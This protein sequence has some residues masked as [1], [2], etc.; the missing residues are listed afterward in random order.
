MHSVIKLCIWAENRPGW[1]KVERGNCMYWKKWV[2]LVTL[3]WQEQ[4]K[5]G[6]QKARET[7]LFIQ[8]LV[9]LPRTEPAESKKIKDKILKIC[10]WALQTAF[11]FISEGIGR[12]FSSVQMAVAENS[13]WLLITCHVRKCS[14]L[15]SLNSMYNVQWIQ[16]LQIY[17]YLGSNAGVIS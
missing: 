4:F 14:Q 2:H 16:Y 9:P 11:P 17:F 7:Q 10:L 12:L 15:H 5:H 13:V 3:H 1:T 8:L 6:C